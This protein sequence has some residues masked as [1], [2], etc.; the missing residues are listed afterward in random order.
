MNGMEKY[1]ATHKRKKNRNNFYI[2]MPK[3]FTKK[4][5]NHFVNCPNVKD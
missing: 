1:F 5:L 3:T 4:A 2:E